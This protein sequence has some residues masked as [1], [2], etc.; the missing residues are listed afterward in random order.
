[1]CMQQLRVPC[2][3]PALSLILPSLPS[4]MDRTPDL[5]QVGLPL[6]FHPP[7]WLLLCS[8]Q[9]V[10][11]GAG[12]LHQG[13]IFVARY[14]HA[15]QQRSQALRWPMKRAQKNDVLQSASVV[16]PR[17][18]SSSE[19]VK[20]AFKATMDPNDALMIAGSNETC[21]GPFNTNVPIPYASVALN[22]GRGYNPSWGRKYTNCTF[23]IR[24]P[25][26]R[27]C[28]HL[29]PFI[30]CLH[31]SKPRC[32]SLFLHCLL[33]SGKGCTHLP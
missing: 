14:Q 33:I 23:K 25:S 24:K 3:N 29:S 27:L 16:N 26:V 22:H 18:K 2:C 6:Y 5:W 4:Q 32:L 17:D 19:S 9:H 12:K 30:R 31:S 11:V 15:E 1:M 8:Q 13:A 21:F 20:I 7:A 28:Q 10:P